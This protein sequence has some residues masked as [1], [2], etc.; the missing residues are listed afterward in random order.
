MPCGLG[1]Y[2]ATSGMSACVLCGAGKYLD[3]EGNTNEAPC[4]PCGLGRYS[5]TSGRSACVP[6]G[7]GQ[8]AAGARTNWHKQN[9]IS[10]SS[11]FVLSF[12]DGVLCMR[13]SVETDAAAPIA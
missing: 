1:Q 13:D 7:L 9:S 3:T 5:N 11:L 6:C 8:Y 4:V 10:R 12:F 2:A